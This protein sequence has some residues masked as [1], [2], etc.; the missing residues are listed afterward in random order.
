LTAPRIP[1]VACGF[2][3]GAL[4]GALPPVQALSADWRCALAGGRYD[5]LLR[6]CTLRLGPA[7]VPASG[8]PSGHASV[9]HDPH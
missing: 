4:I 2:I 6:T 3:A 9:R 8:L 5:A 7:S 1:L